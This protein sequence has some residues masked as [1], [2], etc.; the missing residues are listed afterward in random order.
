MKYIVSI[1]QQAP[2]EEVCARAR[3]HTR[4]RGG[5]R[6]Y[7]IIS[8]PGTV[9]GGFWQRSDVKIIT[10][11]DRAKASTT[12]VQQALRFNLF[13]VLQACAR[14]ENTGVPAKG[15]TG[16]AYEGHYFWD[17]EIYVLPFLTYTAPRIAK[18]LLRF[19]H[20]IRRKRANGRA[21]SISEG[22]CIPGGR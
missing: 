13:H 1:S 4:P 15:L 22:P 21:S 7:R 9:H 10:N 18:N 11:P 3:T 5:D 16:A 20:G 14:A 8:R 12:A 6:I 17:T 2:P 19:R